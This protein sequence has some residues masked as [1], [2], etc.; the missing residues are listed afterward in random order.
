MTPNSAGAS[1]EDKLPGVHY[2]PQQE[3]TAPLPAASPGRG[4]RAWGRTCLISYFPTLHQTLHL[5]F[6]PP[7]SPHLEMRLTAALAVR[8]GK[9]SR[10]NHLSPASWRR[11]IFSRSRSCRSASRT[12][13]EQRELSLELS[14]PLLL[15]PSDLELELALQLCWVSLTM[16]SSL[17]EGHRRNTVGTRQDTEQGAVPAGVGS[18]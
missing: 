1:K 13:V 7:C 18:R 11:R 10:E 2:L 12:G 15:P 16:V 3:S 17:E 14:L 8:G 5:S 4:D 6:R 9:N